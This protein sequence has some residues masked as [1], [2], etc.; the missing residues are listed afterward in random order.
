MTDGR[1]PT[2][3]VGPGES[4]VLPLLR[5]VR[6][7]VARG[8]K[9]GP[10]VW[11]WVPRGEGDPS[12]AQ[13]LGELRDRL[14]PQTMQGAV[15]LLVDGP[16]PP[17]RHE[18]SPWAAA[19]RAVCRDCDA[20]VVLHS[21]PVGCEAAPHMELDLASTTAR[22]IA[23]ALGARF[24]APEVLTAPLNRAIVGAP[25]VTWIDGESERLSRP[26]IDR[27]A[28]ALGSLLG[29]LGITDD[30]I[31]RPEVRVVL[32]AI[33]TVDAPGPGLVE[34]VVTPGAIVMKGQ[35]VAYAGQP[36][37]RAR[38]TLR[39]PANGVVLYARSGQLV[40]G[41]VIG[42][43]KLQR[44]LPAVERVRKRDGTQGFDV[45]WCEHV[46]LP[47]LGIKLRAKIDTGARSSALHVSSMTEVSSDDDGHVLMD[48]E[49]PDGRAKS[50]VTRVMVTEYT[51]VTDSGGHTELRPVIETLLQLG[52]SRERVRVTLTDR[53]DM[54]FPMLV[55]RTGLAGNVRVHPQRRYLLGKR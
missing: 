39:A 45:G 2:L 5:D 9:P 37:T 27:A 28:D 53:G 12:M 42:I 32:K 6:A 17:H 21:L 34:P 16:P 8:E 25:T 24:A 47:E 36:G 15:G 30:V 44:A 40:G 52:E 11:A 41:D 54:R 49:I 13:A 14:S 3:L 38:R 29:T 22:K 33:A 10:I 35:P 55:G 20:L 1:N 51:H 31:V 19:L 50:R 48:I 43:G 18:A 7:F 26:V 4:G 46:S 23:R